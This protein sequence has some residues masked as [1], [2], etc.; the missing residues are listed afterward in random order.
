LINRIS[1]TLGLDAKELLVL[2]SPETKQIVDGARPSGKKG[3]G[4]WQRFVSNKAL[5][6]RHMVTLDELKV[7]KHVLMLEIL[8]NFLPFLSGDSLPKHFETLLASKSSWRSSDRNY[9]LISALLE[10]SGRP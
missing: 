5:L 9:R 10:K 8:L 1:E 6:R 4:A 3:E 2:A 7:L